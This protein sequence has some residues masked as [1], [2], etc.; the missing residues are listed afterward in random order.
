MYKKLKIWM[1]YGR[2]RLHRIVR[3]TSYYLRAA[4]LTSGFFVLFLPLKILLL[5]DLIVIIII[6]KIHHFN[7]G[8][9]LVSA[10][11]RK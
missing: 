4:A 3:C 2:G 7:P 8:N 6:T 5:I 1:G 10:A 9:L 11:A